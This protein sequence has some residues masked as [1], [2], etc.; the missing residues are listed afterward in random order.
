MALRIQLKNGQVKDYKTWFESTDDYQTI[1]RTECKMKFSGIPRELD[2]CNHIECAMKSANWGKEEKKERSR[3]FAFI[4]LFWI[5]VGFT[6]IFEFDW[7]AGLMFAAIPMIFGSYDYYQYI[8]EDDSKEYK[9]LIEFRDNG[10]INGIEARQ[11]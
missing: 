5:I 3:A 7:W 4:G 1:Y 9:E 2:G 6:E 10:T 11:I 8:N